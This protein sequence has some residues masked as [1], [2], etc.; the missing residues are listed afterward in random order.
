VDKNDA[1]D[2]LIEAVGEED[3]LVG[4]NFL[5][6]FSFHGETLVDFLGSRNMEQLFLRFWQK[7]SIF[8]FI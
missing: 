5:D 6:V 7:T 2:G 3:I 8:N 4:V 1:N